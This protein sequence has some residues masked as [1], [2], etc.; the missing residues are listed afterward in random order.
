MPL[1]GIE[2]MAGDGGAD[3]LRGTKGGSFAAAMAKG[4]PAQKRAPGNAAGPLGAPFAFGSAP[5][6][7][8]AGIPEAQACSA[9]GL[10]HQ[11]GSGYP[12][13]PAPTG[14]EVARPTW[15]P[16]WPPLDWEPG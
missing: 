2:P 1:G 5:F 3:G 12:K 4:L 7:R 6:F 13:A 10:A 9:F 16:Y 11:L 8:F 14:C 15:L